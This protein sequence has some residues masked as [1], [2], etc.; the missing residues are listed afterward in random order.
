MGKVAKASKVRDKIVQE[1]IQL[2]K[3]DAGF[4]EL[5]TL[6]P[7]K[8]RGKELGSDIHCITTD[9]EYVEKTK[10][11]KVIVLSKYS[12]HKYERFQELCQ[13]LAQK[14]GLDGATVEDLAMGVRQPRISPRQLRTIRVYLDPVVSLPRDF[15]SNTRY[16]AHR[17]VTP[18]PEAMEIMGR[19]KKLDEQTKKDVKVFLSLLFKDKYGCH[20]IE[21]REAAGPLETRDDKV[22]LDVCLRVPI[23]YTAGEVAEAYQKVDNS[24]REI[25]ASLGIDVPQRRR[26]SKTLMEAEPLRLLDNDVGIYDIIDAVYSDS[27]LSQDQLMRRALKN[28]R[29]KGKKLLKKR[30]PTIFRA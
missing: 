22:E 28:K 1:K 5:I 18:P 15:D 14:W 12:W 23:G 7:L 19:V 6:V 30:Y 16:V 8:L 4:A 25:L 29:C 26:Q 10:D 13:K 20:I 3:A 17:T 27:D 11:R 2:L 9:H 21:L 24:R